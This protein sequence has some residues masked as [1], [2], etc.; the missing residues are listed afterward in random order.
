MQQLYFVRHGQTELNASNH[1]QG[2]QIDS[3]L[4]PNSLID[5]EKT[6]RL[7]RDKKI[8][9]IITSPQQRAMDTAQ[10]IAK[11][12]PHEV[13]IE[14]DP[15]LKEFDYGEWEG[16]FIP[17]LEATYVDAFYN[18][19]HMPDRY[20]PSTFGGETYVELISRGTQAV[21]HHAELHPE[22]DLLFVGHGILTM[23]TILT[24]AGFP[25]KDIRTQPALGNTSV[26]KLVKKGKEFELEMWNYV[27]H[28]D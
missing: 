21:R 7:L 2:G 24:L 17:D 14:E 19:R 4:L 16:A 25:L 23:A 12:F 8:T 28:L 20:D 6:G 9:R 22:S 18:L 27:G 11:Q 13:M 10:L 5:A 15:L 26:S 3:P 1:V